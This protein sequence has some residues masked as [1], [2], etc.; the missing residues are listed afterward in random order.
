METSNFEWDAF[1]KGMDEIT[2]VTGAELRDM[3]PADQKKMLDKFS[4]DSD[5]RT[6]MAGYIKAMSG[7]AVSDEERK[8]YEGAILGGNWST[9][10]TA[11]ASM[12]GFI[13]GLQNGMNSA[14]T[15]MQSE[16]PATYLDYKD[17]V[18]NITGKLDLTNSS[19]IAPS[20][21]ANKEPGFGEKV[22]TNIKALWGKA[23]GNTPSAADY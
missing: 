5:M 21:N 4:F 3:S 10:E 9:K 14:I 23:T 19:S 18:N 12:N 11:L 6:V 17:R 15:G 7:A 8:F 22:K 1:N 20:T 2:K 16:T 13:S